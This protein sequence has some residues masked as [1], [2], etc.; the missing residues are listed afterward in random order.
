ME[1]TLFDFEAKLRSG[2][3]NLL[4][5]IRG[6]VGAVNGFN[7]GS[8]EGT[9]LVLTS[10]HPN[11]LVQPSYGEGDDIPIIYHSCIARDGS[12]YI[13]SNEVI[14]VK[15][16]KGTKAKLNEVFLFATHQPIS[17][18]VVNPIILEAYW[19]N[20]NVSL[21]TIYNKYAK[22]STVEELLTSTINTE[23]NTIL[24]NLS[25]YNANS[26]VLVGI[27]GTAATA[28]GSDPVNFSLPV[29]GSFPT[30]IPK[31]DAIFRLLNNLVNQQVKNS[32]DIASLKT[33]QASIVELT[34]EIN[35]LSGRVGILEAKH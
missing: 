4:A 33:L 10:D 25:Y 7:K 23:L 13:N 30:V 8:I 31:S 26:M 22:L 29:Y 11:Y 1:R 5:S 18:P 9:N 32:E 17:E 27:Y 21:S 15:P 19:N 28:A 2:D 6:G 12:I 14:E 24:S 34:A 3:L 35:L 20:T 16:I